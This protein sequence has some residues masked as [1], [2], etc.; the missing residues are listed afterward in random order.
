MVNPCVPPSERSLRARGG[1]LQGSASDGRLG[2]AWSVQG[3]GTSVRACAVNFEAFTR[4]ALV[5]DERTT[6]PFTHRPRLQRPLMGGPRAGPSPFS[7][8]ALRTVL[9]SVRGALAHRV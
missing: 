8:Q 6:R 5:R 9:E 2:T 4:G 1:C 3:L 7:A